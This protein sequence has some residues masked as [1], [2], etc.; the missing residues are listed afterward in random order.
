MKTAMQRLSEEIENYR[1]ESGN[2]S[3]SIELLQK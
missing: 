1:L 2:E 3:I